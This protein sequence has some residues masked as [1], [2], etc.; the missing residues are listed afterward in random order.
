MSH[1][2]TWIYQKM[3]PKNDI[4]KKLSLI[5]V[6]KQWKVALVISCG[7]LW[8]PCWLVV[9]ITG[10]TYLKPDPWP[11]CQSSGLLTPFLPDSPSRLPGDSLASAH[12]VSGRLHV[13]GWQSAP[14]QRWWS[15]FQEEEGA[16]LLPSRRWTEPV[17][18]FCSSR[19]AQV[20]TRAAATKKRQN[21]KEQLIVW[22][23]FSE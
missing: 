1:M 8:C 4:M 9:S 7:R 20:V 11:W 15:M 16:P 17:R 19:S 13:D 14:E 10:V 12:A 22:W 21:P 2:L 6:W 23:L 18:T 5:C 3:W